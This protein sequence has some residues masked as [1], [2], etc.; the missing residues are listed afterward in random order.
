MGTADATPEMLA[1]CAMA[2]GVAEALIPRAER[3]DAE[4]AGG[5]WPARVARRKI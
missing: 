3:L 5:Y 1:Q 2:S 4:A